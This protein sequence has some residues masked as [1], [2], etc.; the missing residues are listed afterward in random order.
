[1]CH[2]SLIVQAV[3]VICASALPIAAQDTSGN[4]AAAS[5]A[6][7]VHRIFQAKCLECHGPARPKGTFDYVLDL[8]RLA[9]SPQLLVPSKPAESRIW[10]MIDSDKMPPENAAA[11]P[12]SSEQKRVIN[13][14]I[15]AM[16][17]PLPAAFPKRALLWL[18]RF[19][20]PVV[21]FPVALVLA[22]MAGE[23]WFWWLGSKEPQPAVRFCIVLAAPAAVAAAILGWLLAWDGYGAGAPQILLLHRWIGTAAALCVLAIFYLSEKDSRLGSRTTLFRATLLIGGL[24]IG[25]SGHLGGTL[26]HGGGFYNF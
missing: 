8:A 1:M 10:E 2:A 18:G 14:W 9:K 7:E 11:G 4:A 22:A 19:H 12:L 20:I 6:V 23:A 13:R 24:L 25:L 17:P 16:V 15:L 5:D 3:A 26:V 21:H